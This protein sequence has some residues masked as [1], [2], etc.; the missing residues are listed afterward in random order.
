MVSK[1]GNFCEVLGHDLTLRGKS[2]SMLLL[3]LFTRIRD[4]PEPNMGVHVGYADPPLGCR[5]I[6]YVRYIHCVR[7]VRDDRYTS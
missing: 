5:Y 4:L 6:R 2:R 7:Y 1:K 3:L